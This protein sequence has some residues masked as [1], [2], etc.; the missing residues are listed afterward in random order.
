MT[1]PLRDP[2]ADLRERLEATRDAAERLAQETEDALGS[3]DRGERP[4]PGFRTQ[5]EREALRDDVSALA[6]TLAT[7]AELVPEELR[8]QLAEIL[9]QVLLLLRALIDWIVERLPQ[10]AAPEPAVRDIPV[11]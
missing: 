5:A 7:L 9:R 1:E 8:A 3:E 2:L 11:A 10:T 6:T 4:P